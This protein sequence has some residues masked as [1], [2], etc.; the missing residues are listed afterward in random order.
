MREAMF[1]KATPGRNL[2]NT[3]CRMSGDRQDRQCLVPEEADRN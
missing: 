2:L 1:D 3:D